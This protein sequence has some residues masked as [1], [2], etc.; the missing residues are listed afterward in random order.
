[1]KSIHRSLASDLISPRIQ[2]D[3]ADDAEGAACNFAASIASAYRLWSCKI[4]LSEINN[5]LP[6]LDRLLQ[7]KERV[8]KLWHETWNPACKTAVN[9]ATKTI[10]K[11]TRRKAF[12]RWENKIRNCEVTPQVDWPIANSF[13]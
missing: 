7:L 13:I 5:K 10:S 3:T 8:G 9:W 11:M 4:T 12:E 6:E 1:M 2:I